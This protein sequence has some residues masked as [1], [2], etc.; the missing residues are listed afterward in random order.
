[1]ALEMEIL[2]SHSTTLVKTKIYQQL[3]KDCYEICTNHGAH[4]D[5]FY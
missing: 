2:V 1:M 3:L 4:I 5:E